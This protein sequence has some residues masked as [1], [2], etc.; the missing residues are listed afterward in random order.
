MGFPLY[1]IFKILFFKVFFLMALFIFGAVQHVG[2]LFLD[3][4]L[5]LHPLC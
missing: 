3:Q 5:N 4:G 1:F 2:S